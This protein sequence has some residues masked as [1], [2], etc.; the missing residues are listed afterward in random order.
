MEIDFVV[1]LPT[2]IHNRKRYKFGELIAVL[3]TPGQ[4]VR[5]PLSQVTGRE[6]HD[7][8]GAVRQAARHAGIQINIKWDDAYIH[9][10]RREAGSE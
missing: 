10:C 1:A 3:T 4:W 7:K 6:V 5:V 9:V 8:C 2:I